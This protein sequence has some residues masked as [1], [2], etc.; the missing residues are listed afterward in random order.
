MILNIWI[1]SLCISF[2]INWSH[3]ISQNFHID[4]DCLALE[5]TFW[6][7]CKLFINFATQ[8]LYMFIM[9]THMK[10]ELTYF[11]SDKRYISVCLNLMISAFILTSQYAW[12]ICQRNKLL[13]LSRWIQ[14]FFS[15][16]MIKID[17]MITRLINFN[18][19]R[20]ADEFAFTHEHSILNLLSEEH[21]ASLN[22]EVLRV[23]SFRCLLNFF[24]WWASLI[25][26][27]AMCNKWFRQIN[28]SIFIVLSIN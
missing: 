12:W 6:E 18:D 21:F 19:M 23:F 5:L 8:V 15:Q 24:L 27:C 16:L 3:L 4:C 11:S 20:C 2:T 13:F 7:W 17:E 9:I 14:I 10:L 1:I 28:S 22:W 26:S 25:S